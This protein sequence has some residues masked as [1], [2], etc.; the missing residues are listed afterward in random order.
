MHFSGSFQ[1]GRQ[2]HCKQLSGNITFKLIKYLDTQKQK[3]KKKKVKKE[4]KEKRKK[5]KRKR[6][7]KNKEREMPG[8]RT[9]D[10]ESRVDEPVC[11]SSYEKLNE[12][13]KNF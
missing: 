1:N 7:K 13:V 8:K 6:K 5:K 12:N 2:F 9:I 3:Q 4:L 10:T 11:L